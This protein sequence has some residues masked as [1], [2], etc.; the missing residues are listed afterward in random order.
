MSPKLEIALIVIML[1]SGWSEGVFQ[2]IWQ[3]FGSLACAGDARGC[4]AR[5]S[6]RQR[7]CAS[8]GD[9]LSSEKWQ[10]STRRS[11]L[12]FRGCGDPRSR[13]IPTS[14][15]RTAGDGHQDTTVGLIVA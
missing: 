5:G 1:T 4:F 11:G 3:F 14:P 13:P 12:A 7:Q 8:R 2:F 10:S 6:I 9:A 15:G